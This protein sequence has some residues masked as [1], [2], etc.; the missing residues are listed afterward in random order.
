MAFVCATGKIGEIF[1]DTFDEAMV[2]G[3]IENEYLPNYHI[4]TTLHNNFDDGFW[5]ATIVTF[6]DEQEIKKIVCISIINMLEKSILARY[7]LRENKTLL[8]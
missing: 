7:H 2:I 4:L 6:G 1:H 8:T 3:D 5:F